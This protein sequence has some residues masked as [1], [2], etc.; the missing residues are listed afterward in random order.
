MSVLDVQRRSQQIGRIRIGQKVKTAKGG[1]RPAK[2]DTFRFTTASKTTAEAV[3]AL[4]AEAEERGAATERARL[5]GSVHVE[6][7]GG[8]DPLAYARV[9]V[10]DVGVASWNAHDEVPHTS[11]TGENYARVCAQVLRMAIVGAS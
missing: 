3:A 9:F 2:L 5:A 10:G 4:V 7:V 1:M 6:V 8:D 11:A